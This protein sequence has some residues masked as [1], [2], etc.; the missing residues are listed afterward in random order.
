MN[1]GFFD[2]SDVYY[3]ISDVYRGNPVDKCATRIHR[4]ILRKLQEAKQNIDIAEEQREE[5]CNRW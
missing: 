4:K 3:I 5:D 2:F 1:K